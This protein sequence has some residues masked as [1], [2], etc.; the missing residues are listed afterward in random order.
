MPGAFT[1]SLRRWEASGDPI[2]IIFA[3]EWDNLDA[4]IGQVQQAKELLAGD[5]LLPEG[6]KGLGGLW[7]RGGLNMDEEFAARVWKKMQQRTLKQFSFAYD[8]LDSKRVS[9]KE[10]VSANHYQ[11][12]LELD[13]ME[14]GPCLVG[15]NPETELLTVKRA[16][17]AYKAGARHTAKEFEQIQQIHDLAVALGAQCKTMGNDQADEGATEDE[18]GGDESDGK[19]EQMTP[20]GRRIMIEALFGEL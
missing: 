7:V 13:L 14:V 2:P 11:D 4:H 8:V 18:A 15:M 16:L 6:L 12:L 5:E 3:H 9:D 1:E 10:R 17:A 19:A 20:S